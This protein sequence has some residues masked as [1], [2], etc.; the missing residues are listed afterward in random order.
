MLLLQVTLTPST[1]GVPPARDEALGTSSRTGFWQRDR[2]HSR[3]EGGWRAQFNQH[4]VVIHSVWVV[5][6]VADDLG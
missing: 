5:S 1:Q 4:D 2:R 6:G 3:V